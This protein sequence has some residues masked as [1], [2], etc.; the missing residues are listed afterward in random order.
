ME[1][2]PAHDTQASPSVPRTAETH[3]GEG[4]PGQAEDWRDRGG[5]RHPYALYILGTATLFLFLLL[6][7]YLALSNDWIPTR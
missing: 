2:P 4:H 7:A 1:K 3:P 6:M 5:W